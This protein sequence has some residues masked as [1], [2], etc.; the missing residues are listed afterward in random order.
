ML[1]L[2]R[3][4]VVALIAML[5][6]NCA[7]VA[8]DRSVLVPIHRFVRAANAGD[9]TALISA[10]SG[11]S[12]IVDEFAPFRFPAPRAAA[13]WYDGFAADQAANGVSGAVIAYAPPKFVT[14]SGMH[15]YV[16]LPTVY[17]Y[18]IHGKPA[19]EAGSLAFALT[20]HDA[21]W[22]ISAMAWAKLTDTSQP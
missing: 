8:G 2:C 17:T 18:K 20:R 13:H 22:E 19:K 14:V 7:A 3:T 9:R 21:R 6:L 15:A 10:F 12:V 1:L 11:D 4:A 16:V 5:G